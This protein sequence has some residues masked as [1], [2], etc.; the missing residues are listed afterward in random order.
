M[1]LIEGMLKNDK[2]GHQKSFFNCSKISHADIGMKC[3]Y[4]FLQK[5]CKN[6]VSIMIPFIL[7]N[8]CHY[9]I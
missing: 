2:V 5:T 3:N 6:A 8:L 1:A 4:M 7:I 9:Q